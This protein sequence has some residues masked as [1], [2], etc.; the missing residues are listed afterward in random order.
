MNQ[1]L[2]NGYSGLANGTSLSKL[3]AGRRPPIPR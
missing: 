3:L 2:R 1:A